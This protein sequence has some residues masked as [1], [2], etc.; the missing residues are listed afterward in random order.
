MKDQWP[1]IYAG[2]IVAVIAF[3]LGMI[4]WLMKKLVNT[5]EERIA[6][7]EGK[8]VELAEDIKNNS[9]KNSEDIKRM[10]EILLMVALNKNKTGEP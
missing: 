9:N 8:V 4:G 6:G 2:I 1:A 3:L 7:L 5:H 10:N